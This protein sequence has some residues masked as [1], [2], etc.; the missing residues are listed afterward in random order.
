MTN[1]LKKFFPVFLLLQAL[2]L[3]GFSA[4]QV[5]I[6]DDAP[7]RYEVV[8]GDTLWDISGRF[9]ED[10]WLW[11]EVWELNPQIENPHLIYPG[12]VIAL[13]YSADGPMLTLTRG[14]AET[15]GLRTIRL[16]PMVRREPINSAI[17][18]IPLDR[19]SAFLKGTI[20]VSETELENSP[21]L[22]G[23]RSGTLLT[24]NNKEVFAKGNWD[25]EINQYNIVRGGQLYRDPETGEVVGV[26]GKHIGTATMVNRDGSNATLLTVNIEEEV[27]KG[28]RFI[29]SSGSRIDPNYFPRPPST[30]IEGSIID[31]SFGRTVGNLYDT[32]VINR[33]SRNR[34]RVGNLLALQKPDIEI[35]DDI[36]KVNLGQQVK[37]S[38]GF[39]NDN[40]ETFSGEKYA[41]V[42]IYRVFEEASLGIIV[43]ADQAVR[44]KDKVVSP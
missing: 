22:L 17:P 28:D 1:S 24:D 40:I 3:M 34:L 33:G 38:L 11:P 32:I 14:G 25:D 7:D 37:Q 35:E 2:S 16:S 23:N 27:R 41:T 21:Y 8:V 6:R 10:P 30:T 26:E 9:L 20:I 12:D 31:I 43:S 29:A 5:Q 19:I 15:S 4:D 44:L 13:E 36:G 39:S 18:A 42:L